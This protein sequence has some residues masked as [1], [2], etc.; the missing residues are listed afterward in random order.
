[1]HDANGL[2]FMI[3]VPPQTLLDGRGV[4][5]AAPV[6]FDE[7]RL[8]PEAF[9]QPFP[10]CR[11]MA[12]FVH[13]HRVAGR[14]CIDQRRLPRARARGGIDH[15]PGLGAEDPFHAMQHLL[16]QLGKAWSAMID[17]RHIHCPKNSVGDV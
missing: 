7:D 9:R 6:A 12:C 8:Q 16:A 4:G 13:Q 3:G 5:A 1:M 11:E 17:G 14:E 15:H 2:D 10:Q